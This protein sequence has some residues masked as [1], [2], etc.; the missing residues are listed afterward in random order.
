MPKT[1]KAHNLM[2]YDGECLRRFQKFGPG[3][4]EHDLLKR[5]VE[6]R[7]LPF[8]QL[9]RN[10]KRFDNLDKTTAVDQLENC[11]IELLKAQIIEAD[12]CA[13]IEGKCGMT[14]RQQIRKIFDFHAFTKDAASTLG[15]DTIVGLCFGG[16]QH[17]QDFLLEWKVMTQNAGVLLPAEMRRYFLEQ[18]L[19]GEHKDSVRSIALSWHLQRFHEA[20]NAGPD[21][22]TGLF[23]KEY[24]EQFLLDRAYEHLMTI[25]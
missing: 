13:V 3:I 9:T 8:E 19:S 5:F 18:K 1:P 7:S 11:S 22:E 21:P 17:M 16:D 23:P 10:D 2:Y 20:K 14:G 15:V 24:S 12:R 6:I 4:P 25:Q